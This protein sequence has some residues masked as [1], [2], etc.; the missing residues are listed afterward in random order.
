MRKGRPRRDFPVFAEINRGRLRAVICSDQADVNESGGHS[1]HSWGLGRP[2]GTQEGSR[3]CSRRAAKPP[4]QEVAMACALTGREKPSSRRQTASIPRP[5]GPR[6]SRPLRAQTLIFFDFRWFH[7]RL[8]SRRPSGTNG[9]CASETADM[10]I[11]F[12]KTGPY[13]LSILRP[14]PCGSL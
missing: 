7:H 8:P 13:R 1:E 14:V 12:L 6:F 3:W 11:R 2:G 4:D 5:D 10:P 9:C